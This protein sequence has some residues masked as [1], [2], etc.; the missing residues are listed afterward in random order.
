MPTY[1]AFLRAINLGPT[2]KF[3]KAAIV[4]AVEDCGF[5]DVETYI[6]TG[7]VRLTSSLRSAAKVEQALEKA[8]KKHAGFEVP[9]IV[10]TPK[11]LKQI[12]ADATEVAKKHKNTGAHYVSLL[13]EKPKAADVKK[14]EDIDHG[15]DLVAV[16]GRGAHLLWSPVGPRPAEQRHRREAASAWPPTATSRWSGTSRRS[17]ADERPRGRRR[18]RS[19]APRPEPAGPAE[20]PH[21]RD[22]R[23][24]GRA[25]RAR[26]APATTC[27]SWSS[28]AAAPAFCAGA[29]IG[30]E[31][32]HERF[33]VRALDRANRMVRAVVGLDKPVLAAV[34]GVAAGVGCSLALACDL[35]VAAERATFLLP[36]TGI[37][38]MPDGGA[39][40]TVAASIGRARA[41][42]MALLAE[43][44]SAAD[45]YAAGLVSHLVADEE[46][47]RG[48]RRR[49]R[50]PAARRP[51]PR[52]RRHE[53]RRQRRRPRTP[54]KGLGARADRADCA[55]PDRR[56]RRRDARVH[57]AAPPDVRR[58]V[59]WSPRS[60][61]PPWSAAT[62]TPPRRC[63]PR[64]SCSAA[65]R[66]S[67]R[68]KARQ[69]PSC[70]S[71]PSRGRSATSTTSAPS[72]RRTA[73]ASR[74]SSRPRSA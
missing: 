58:G 28:P 14:L 72:S 71:R 29:D 33:D 44:M 23:R 26:A 35:V 51:T 18:R 5:T 56:R 25:P 68:T 12:A 60:S 15:E 27:A 64:T 59:T 4:E 9:T 8:F 37:G 50:R 67:S 47:L 74:R 46:A 42:R 61:S 63:W 36:F 48:D 6:N 31:E 40:A 2:R 16:K 43:P 70:C 7:N 1:V 57:R 24:S 19:P 73:A 21:R 69:P 32:A 49:A 53:A 52:V 41:M 39:T 38:L 22:D 13:K 17:G 66:S 65:R 3:P 62:S 30:G 55:A 34:H 10:M 45:A 11:E 54:R 20:R